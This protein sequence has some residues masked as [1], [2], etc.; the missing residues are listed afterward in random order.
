MEIQAPVPFAAE[1]QGILDE[2]LFKRKLVL[3]YH[4]TK[5]MPPMEVSE[6]LD[7]P[8]QTV[9]DIIKRWKERGSIEDQEGRGR[10]SPVPNRDREMVVNLQKN[11]RRRTG[12]SIHREMM[13]NGKDI[14]YGQTLAIINDTFDSVYAP[15]KIELREVNQGKRVKWA[16]EHSKW[17]TC[18]FNTVVWTD[19]KIFALVPLGKKLRVKILPGEVLK[20]FSLDKPFR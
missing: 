19:E 15:Y 18:K 1:L 5:K 12:A 6:E 14:S 3:W 2:R 7:M 20:R 13:A 9:R 10:K 16:Q 4:F 8:I 11:D 17:R